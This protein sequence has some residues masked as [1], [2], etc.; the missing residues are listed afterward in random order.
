MM[1]KAI[2]RFLLF[3]LAAALAFGFVLSPADI[4]V[5]D[6]EAIGPLTPNPNINIRPMVDS[7]YYQLVV[8]IETQVLTV[9]RKDENGDYTVIDRQMACSTARPGKKTPPGTF[10]ISTKVRWLSSPTYHTYEQFACRIDGK[11]WIHST[12]FVKRDSNTLETDSYLQL[13]EPVSAGCIR[14]TVRDILWIYANCPGGTVVK[15]VK[16]GGPLAVC[17][18]DMP[19]LPAGTAYDPTDPAVVH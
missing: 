8:D 5:A 6:S 10:K 1:K 18:T 16:D 14:L 19:E 3:A 9:L 12:C 15:V 13:G 7:K 17:L 11:I 2:N 4:A